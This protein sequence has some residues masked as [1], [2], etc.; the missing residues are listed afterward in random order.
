M[1]A[2]GPKL[3][4]KQDST[5]ARKPRCFKEL[6]VS[7]IKD[8]EAE[9]KSL[10]PF[11]IQTNQEA[12]GFLRHYAGPRSNAAQRNNRDQQETWVA[13]RSPRICLSAAGVTSPAKARG[14]AHHNNGHIKGK[15][16]E[17]RRRAICWDEITR[18]PAQ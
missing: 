5:T 18:L 1:L 7:Q 13:A 15:L 11:S 12:E 3:R 4:E 14:Q 9:F 16:A 6:Q 17:R 2:M 10:T 8:F